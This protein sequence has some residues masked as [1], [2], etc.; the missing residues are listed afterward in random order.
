MRYIIKHWRGELPLAVSFWINL[1]FINICLRFIESWLVESNAIQSPVLGSQISLS[2]V[3]LALFIVYP[4]QIIGTWRSA[5]RHIEE[6]SRNG[7]AGA[8]KGLIIIGFMATVANVYISIPQYKDAVLIGFGKDEYGEYHVTLKKENTL[9]HLMG[10]LGH[11]VAADV[12]DLLDKNPQVTGIVLDSQ[13][14]WIYEGRELYKVIRSN[15]LDTYSLK[16]C[17]SACITAFI[18]GDTRYLAEGANLAFHQYS[19]A[20]KSFENII[21]MQPEMRQDIEIYRKQGVSQEFIDKMFLAS[22]DDFWYPT[23]DELY[24]GNVVHG[25][26][27]PSTIL[28]TNYQKFD[29]D[30]VINEL[31]KYSVYNTI[32]KYDSRTYN[33][34]V[35]NIKEKYTRGASLLEIQITTSQYL[36]KI[37]TDSLPYTSNEAIVLFFKTLVEVLQKLNNKDP[38]LCLKYVLPE[39]YGALEMPNSMSSEE[40]QSISNV[41]SIVIIDRYEKTP[42]PTNA[43]LVEERFNIILTKMG[44]DVKYLDTSKINNKSDYKNACNTFIKYYSLILEDEQYAGPILRYVISG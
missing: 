41:L 36:E 30:E 21:D 14:G 17:Y 32:K 29:I 35:T 34:I 42:E 24:Y 37:A 6:T 38:F 40:I 9:I 7:W 10:G 22:K 16:G 15:N 19:A 20:G 3:F 26:L 44:D 28:P 2:F 11:G 5:N 8:T 4:W 27:N 1:F 13:G 31:N 18:G 23:I 25:V 33:Q 39:K 12:R 43:S